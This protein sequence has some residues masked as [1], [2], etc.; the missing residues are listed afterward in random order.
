MASLF[1]DLG[2]ATTFYIVAFE[3]MSHSTRLTCSYAHR[4]QNTKGHAPIRDVL[5]AAGVVLP[6]KVHTTRSANQSIRRLSVRRNSTG[7]NGTLRRNSL[8]TLVARKASEQCWMDNRQK[9]LELLRERKNR[10]RGHG[11][12]VGLYEST[13]SG[14]SSHSDRFTTDERFQDSTRHW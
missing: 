6:S 10:R 11:C 13:S 1:L 2:K 5:K 14:V 12:T 9:S 8:D 3:L 4:M 7:K